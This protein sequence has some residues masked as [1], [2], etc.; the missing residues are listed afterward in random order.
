MQSTPDQMEEQSGNIWVEILQFLS[1]LTLHQTD[2]FNPGSSLLSFL[3]GG[4]KVAE[5]IKHRMGGSSNDWLQ[6]TLCRKLFAD[7]V[8]SQ[9]NWPLL[10]GLLKIHRL[11]S[12]LRIRLERR[13]EN[14]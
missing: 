2:A 10:T 7:S 5:T 3:N 8:D 11:F 9:T 4:F 12:A 14:Q 6:G 1:T 13:E